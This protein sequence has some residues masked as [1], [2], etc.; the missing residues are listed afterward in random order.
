MKSVNTRNFRDQLVKDCCIAFYDPYFLK[1]LD[2]KPNLIGCKNG[3]F[4]ID[5]G[6]FCDCRPTDYLT[7]STNVEYLTGV[8][9]DMPQY[10]STPS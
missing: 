2:S 6:V 7:F 8:I 5:A 9:H 4:D 10:H 3:V 1:K